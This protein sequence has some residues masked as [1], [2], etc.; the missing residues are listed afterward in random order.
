MSIGKCDIYPQQ[1][2]DLRHL[3]VKGLTKIVTIIK[4]LTTGITAAE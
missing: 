4:K 2:H 3:G 1:F